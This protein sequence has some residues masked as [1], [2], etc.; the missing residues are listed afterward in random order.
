M[1]YT[2]K[3]IDRFWNNVDVGEPDEC[4]PWKLSRRLD[5]YGQVGMLIDGDNRILKAHKVAWELHN[6]TQLPRNTRASHSCDNPECCNPHH[7]VVHADRHYAEYGIASAQV[8]GEQHGRSKLTEKQAR[9]IKYRLN[10]LT[11]RE[12]ADAFSVAFHTVWDIRKGVTWRH[13]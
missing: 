5:G 8:R 7:V 11:T 2:Q 9:I 4:W 12:I 10:A 6:K 13:I 3:Q 1:I